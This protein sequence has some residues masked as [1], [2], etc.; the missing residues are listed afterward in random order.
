MSLPATGKAISL[1]GLTRRRH[2]DPGTD[3]ALRAN[4][5]WLR[6]AQ[7]CSASQDGGVAHSYDWLT[8]WKSSYPETTGY[9]VP[10]LLAYSD[11][12]GDAAAETAARRMLDWLVSIQLEDGAFQGGRVDSEPRV[13]VTFNTGQILLGLAAGADRFG[14]AYHD[15]MR[16]AADWLVTTQDSDGCWRSHPSPFAM[17]GDRTYDT[18]VAWGLLEAARVVPD[19]KYGDAG[20]ANVRWALGHQQENGWFG[21]CCLTDPSRPLTHTIGYTLRGVLEGYRFSQEADLLEASQRTARALLGVMQPNGFIA[22]RLD[23]GWRPAASWACL[24]GIV[25]IALCWLQLF[26]HT[27]DADYLT[28]AR[29]ANSFVRSTM[30]MSGKPDVVGA[31]GGSFPLYGE[32]GRYSYLNWAA[33]FCADSNMLEARLAPG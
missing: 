15:A 17:P 29:T 13:A 31:V 7:D 28:A 4:I 6:R 3:A 14:A 2:D 23:A 20:L 32:Y 16:A 9:I 18:H 10:T 5:A 8:G 25:Q 1:R 21:H 19:S 22:G 12:A 27:G 11:L 33:K 26:E 24:T 30:Y